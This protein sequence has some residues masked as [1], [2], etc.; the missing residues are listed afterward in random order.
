M[1]KVDL[2]E[3]FNLLD[4][5]TESK[6]STL[7]LTSGN[8]S[9]DVLLFEERLVLEDAKSLDATAVFFRRFADKQS[10]IPQL[11]I[12][13]NTNNIKINYLFINSNFIIRLNFYI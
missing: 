2:S 12:F 10:S 11:F 1:R 7:F 3:V 6:N 5:D 13:D 8:Y 4:F 9:K